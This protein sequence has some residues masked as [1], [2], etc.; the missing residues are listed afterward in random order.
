MLKV[1]KRGILKLLHQIYSSFPKVEKKNHQNV[2]RSEENME[3]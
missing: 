1:I 2:S 3:Q